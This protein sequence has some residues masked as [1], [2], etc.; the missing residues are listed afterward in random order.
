M[1]N[2]RIIAIGG[3][4]VRVTCQPA[5]T[6]AIDREAVRLAASELPAGKTV[7][8]LFIPTASRD[9]I[10]YCHNI[11]THF[12]LRLGC[13]YDHLRLLVD[14]E[15]YRQISDKI[16]WADII[17]VGGGNTRDMMKVWRE[18]GV[19]D[20]LRQAHEE[21]KVLMGLSAGSICWFHG[22]L[23]DSNKFDGDPDWQPMWV[24][25]LGL[26]PLLHSPHFDSELWRRDEMEGYRRKGTLTRPVLA[27][28]DNC[29]LEVIGDQH[30]IISSQPGPKAYFYRAKS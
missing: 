24:A 4:S 10:D 18:D 17:Y 2:T 29:A 30:R 22:G 8:V 21:G 20:L 19:D 27:L 14:H 23:S 5:T 15:Y 9:D 13:N 26:L 1:K 6:L 11:Y 28:Q 16:A 3:G 12:G 7:N 25:G